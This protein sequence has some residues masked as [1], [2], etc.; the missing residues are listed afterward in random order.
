[1][2]NNR[3][4]TLLE[5]TMV[6]FIIAT[7]TSISFGNMKSVYD[8]SGRNEFIQQL[9]QDILYAQQMAISHS[10]YTSV[11]FLNGSKEYVIRQGNGNVLLRREFSENTAF[12]PITLSL[13]DVAFL[14]DGNVRRSGTMEIRIDDHRY[15]FVLLLGRGRFYIE[16]L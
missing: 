5:M 16:K 13:N 2:V 11:I 8:A 6:L 14:A 1:M 12:V 10:M 7:V 15:R 9:Q 3:G 4:Y